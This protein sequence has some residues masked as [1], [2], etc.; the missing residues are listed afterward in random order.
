MHV[1]HWITCSGGAIPYDGSPQIVV[2][3]IHVAITAVFSVLG[4]I[5]LIMAVVALVFNLLFRNKRLVL[6]LRNAHILKQ[7]N[8]QGRQAW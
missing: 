8:M 4:I 3:G 5:G 2:D 1:C 6:S 7:H